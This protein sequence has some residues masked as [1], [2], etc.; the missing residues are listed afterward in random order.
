YHVDDLVELLQGAGFKVDDWTSTYG[1]L[2]TFCQRFSYWIT[3]AAMKRAGLYALIY[4]V[5]RVIAFFG[6]LG[7]PGKKGTNVLA[8]A[9]KV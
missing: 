2:E 3:G 4:P 9:T 6:G 1:S 5:L 7:N 8:V